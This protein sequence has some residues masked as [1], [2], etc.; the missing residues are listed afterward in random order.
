MGGGLS[1]PE[2]EDEYNNQ[3]TRLFIK[4][5]IF[6]YSLILAGLYDFISNCNV[7]LLIV[8]ITDVSQRTNNSF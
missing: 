8:Y 4:L 2:S 6:K 7:G 3:E 5:I 1:V